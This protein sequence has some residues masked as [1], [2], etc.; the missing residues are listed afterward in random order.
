MPCFASQVVGLALCSLIGA[1][2]LPLY[3]AE[4]AGN[5]SLRLP[6]SEAWDRVFTR[7]SAGPAMTHAWVGQITEDNQGFLWLA[8]R[9]GLLRYDGYQVRPY[10]PYSNGIRGSGRFEEC[11]PTLSLVPGMSRYSLL[12]DGS[13]KMWIG[14]DE[15]LHQYDSATD[16]IRRFPFHEG[17]LQGFVRSVY[18]D[19][20]GAVWLATTH[21][22]IRFDAK[23]GQTET[24]LHRDGDAATLAA[25]QVRSTVESR[26]RKFWVATNS[27]LD[28]FDRHTGKVIEHLSLRNPLQA[29]PTIGNPY[30]RML[31][32][33]S[34]T[35]WIASARD[36]L[37]FMTP[38]QSRLTFIALNSRAQPE[39]GVWAILEDHNEGIW[40]GSEHGLFKLDHDREHLV[41]YRNNPADAT[42]LPADWVLALHEDRE[43]GIWVGTADGGA[44]RFSEDQVPF[45]RYRRADSDGDP[46]NDYIFTAYESSDGSVWAGG[47][48][49]V[50]RIDLATGRYLVRPL[51]EDTEVRAITEY[52]AGRL[53]LGLLDGGLYRLTPATGQ[54]TIYKHGA[55]NSQGCDNNEVRAFHVDHLGQLWVGGS[56]SLCA[57]D[58]VKD[59]F[60]A[61]KSPP[62]GLAEIDAISE[63]QDGALWIGSTH[64]GLYRFDPLTA[65]FTPYRHS[66]ATGS[67]SNNIVTSVL[68]DRSGAVWAGTVDGLNVLNKNTG[69]FRTYR[70]ADGLPS[71]IVNGVVEDVRGRL[72]ITTSYGL[73]QLD[74][75]AHSF[76]GYFR[77]SGVFDDLTGA[78]VGRHGRLFFGAYSGLTVLATQEIRDKAYTPSVVL[79]DLQI[80]D[81]PVTVG[82]NSP[83]QHSISNTKSLTLHH[84]KNT[85]SFEF[86]ALTFSAPES[87]HYRY[88]LR[89]VERDWR[90]AQAGQHSVRYS[91]LAAGRYTFEVQTRAKSGKWIEQ[92]ATIAVT[93]LP[94]FWATWQFRLFIASLLVLLLWQTH[95]HRLRRLSRQIRIR[96]EERLEERTRIAQDLHDTLLQGFV[97]VSMQ[98]HVAAD[99][100]PEQSPAKTRLRNILDLMGKVVDESRRTVRGLRSV[101]EDL[102]DL[103]R[104]FSHIVNELPNAGDVRFRVFVEG[105]IRALHPL[106]QD[107]VYRIGREAIMNAF[108]HATAASVEVTLEYR[109][110]RFRLLVRDDGRGL[111]PEVLRAG[112]EGHFGMAGMRERA[113]RIGGHLRILS[114]PNSGTD[115]ELI[116][117]R[118]SAY[119]FTD[120]AT[121][122]KGV[123][124]RRSL[125]SDRSAELFRQ[126][127]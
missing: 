41:R 72:W 53:W 64:S 17:L 4:E 25:N 91:T 104:A 2:P 33:R 84:D 1:S 88:R 23:T 96:F 16:Q 124:P 30:V 110:I 18:Q 92:G 117:P 63:D 76:T 37:A 58:P 123:L 15:S 70:E 26:D 67:L 82:G 87:T 45:R 32:D 126:Q 68:V 89:N 113:Q 38:G 77:S 54:S 11:C 46:G 121:R 42:A 83:L 21:G 50:Y 112:R 109:E 27:T 7:M 120:E 75:I 116:I 81:Q 106:V 71:N 10:Y 97:S 94:P 86:A 14:G 5:S 57:Y 12:N 125:T 28:L 3:G 34:G 22:L 43:D 100:I 115:V 35:L 90:E 20:E 93:I 119:Q 31:E 48:G 13:G 60:R 80:S 61:Y 8:T 73:C 56:D 49:K 51:P 95:M 101:H 108:R 79:T 47:K 59:R 122:R 111:E 39:P 103:Q 52:P 66:N 55:R 9:D 65:V 85:L 74:P 19:R 78:W 36:G 98:L 127:D 62:P 102:P 114:R 24:F 6:I 118:K 105:T 40:I 107:E 99:S 69:K 29:S 44:A